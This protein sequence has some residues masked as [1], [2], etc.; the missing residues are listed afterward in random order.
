VKA[1]RLLQII[2]VL[3]A[4]AYLVLLHDLNQVNVVLPFLFSLPPSVVLLLTLLLGWLLGWLPA[5]LRGVGRN[6]ELRRLRRRIAELEPV[7]ETS[8]VT[9]AETPVIPDRRTLVDE[10]E[11]IYPEHEN[12]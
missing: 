8:L 11:D 5:T 10:D 3:A 1:V 4:G 9:D 7:D 12:L 2:I 6:R